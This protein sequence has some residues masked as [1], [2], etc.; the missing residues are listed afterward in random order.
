MKYMGVDPGGAAALIDHDGSL[1][2]MISFR[3]HTLP[4]IA[5][6]M[7]RPSYGVTAVIEKL[8]PISMGRIALFKTGQHYGEARALCITRGFKTVEITPKRWKRG[9]NLISPDKS[10]AR[11]LAQQLWPTAGLKRVKDHD[12]A[13]ALLIAEYARRE[14]L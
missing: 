12:L 13:E 1:I 3:E 9:M 6:W 7:D 8:G 2:G 5:D 4:E 14:N 10:L 11:Q